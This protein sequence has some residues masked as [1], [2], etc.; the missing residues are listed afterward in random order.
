[1]LV[2][3]ATNVN[4]VA[5]AITRFLG[6]KGYSTLTA[7]NALTTLG[8]SQIYFTSAGSSADAAEVASA[9]GLTSAAIQPASSNPPVSS[10]AGAAVVVVAGQDLATRFAPPTTTTTGS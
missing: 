7:V 9:L 1:M 10:T 6:G 3:N 5:G 4:G 2:A 8:S